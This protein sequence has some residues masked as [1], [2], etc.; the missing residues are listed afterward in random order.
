MRQE[1][2][3]AFTAAF[4]HIAAVIDPIF[5]DLTRSRCGLQKTRLTVQGSG[6]FHLPGHVHEQAAI[7]PISAPIAAIPYVLRRVTQDVCHMHAYLIA[8]SPQCMGSTLLLEKVATCD[9]M[10]AACIPWA[11]R[12]I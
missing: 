4:E 2:Y 8:R 6:S 12:P 11:A 1:R 3:D 7:A 9:E 5:K 10:R